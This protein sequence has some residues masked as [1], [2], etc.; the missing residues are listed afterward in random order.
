[1]KFY[2]AIQK[3]LAL[4]GPDRGWG[5]VLVP[6]AKYVVVPED[7]GLGFVARGGGNDLFVAH[8]FRLTGLAHQPLNRVGYIMVPDGPPFP[9]DEYPRLMAAYRK[10]ERDGTLLTVK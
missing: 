1:M 7:G 4:Y 8:T 9:S 2:D 5:R 3:A 10:A 6:G